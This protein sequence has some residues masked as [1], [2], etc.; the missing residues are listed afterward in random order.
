M[1]GNG[2]LEK[3]RNLLRDTLEELETSKKATAEARQAAGE[4]ALAAEVY[5]LCIC[6]FVKHHFLNRVVHVS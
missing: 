3:M 5:H 2:E 1:Q 6:P 4:A